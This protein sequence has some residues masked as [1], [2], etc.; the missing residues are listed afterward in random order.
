LG[1][2]TI[3]SYVLHG[4]SG[5]VGLAQ[6]DWQAWRAMEAIHNS[7]RVRLLGVS[8]VTLEQ[9]RSLC[10]E[11]KVRPSFVQNR[12][13]AATAWDRDVRSFC[14]AEGI[15][16]QGF[17]LLTANRK[18]IAGSAVGRI[19]ERHGRTKSQ[20]V[21]RFALDVGMIA[22]TGTTNAD[23]MREDLDIFDFRLA[24]EELAQ[25]ETLVVPG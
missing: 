20:T 15:V 10:Q 12:C 23:H 17:S 25:I 9:L 5:N 19:A 6:A 2:E 24:P 22:L 13:Y 4:P 8:N 7:G 21:F 11:A 14:A 3:D 16:Y 1:I 18:A